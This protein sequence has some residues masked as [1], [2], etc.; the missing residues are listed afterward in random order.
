MATGEVVVRCTDPT[1]V[2]KTCPFYEAVEPM[3]G[4]WGRVNG[5]W[6][7]WDLRCK[8]AAIDSAC[9]THSEARRAAFRAAFREAFGLTAEQ[10]PPMVSEA[11]VLAEFAGRLREEEP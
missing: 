2:R 5:I 11:E 7:Y 3:Q 1:G 10:V 8:H 6:H 4:E 9:C